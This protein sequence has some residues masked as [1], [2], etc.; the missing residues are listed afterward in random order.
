MDLWLGA[1][2]L[3]QLPLVRIIAQVIDLGLVIVLGGLHHY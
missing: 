1:K 3:V 2:Q